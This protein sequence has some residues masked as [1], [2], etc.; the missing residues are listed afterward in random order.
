MDATH[1]V[2]KN[3]QKLTLCPH[4]KKNLPTPGLNGVLNLIFKE[5]MIEIISDCIDSL[6][7]NKSS[8]NR[9]F[10]YYIKI[11]FPIT[12]FDFS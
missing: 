2:K 12:C 9:L 7:E 11:G 1:D 8:N 4:K 3:S 5:W 6:N 10:S